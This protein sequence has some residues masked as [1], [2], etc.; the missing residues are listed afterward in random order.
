M[1]ILDT[2]ILSAMMRLQVEPQVAAWIADRPA[3][4]LFTTALSEAEILSGLAILDEGRRRRDLEAAARVMFVED[5]AGRVLPF[6]GKA[7]AAYATLFAMRR[8]AGRP[9]PPLDLLIAAVARSHGAQV[10]TRNVGDFEGCGLK[11]INPWDHHG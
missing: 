10:V 6:D 4:L 9:V 5:F 3:N 7:V 11:L 2:N 8:Q 1:F